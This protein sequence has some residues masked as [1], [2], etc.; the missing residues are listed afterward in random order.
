[1]AT[2]QLVDVG[3]GRPARVVDTSPS[4]LNFSSS[5]PRNG[6]KDAPSSADVGLVKVAVD[7]QVAASIEES[8]ISIS[9]SKT[10]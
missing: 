1:M 10:I 4:N 8:D 7:D 5:P 3:A 9:G 2:V 6:V